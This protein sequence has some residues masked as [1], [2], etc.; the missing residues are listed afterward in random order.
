MIIYIAG[1]TGKD[2]DFEK[3][4]QI[5]GDC[6]ELIAGSVGWG[7]DCLAN[8]CT[9]SNLLRSILLDSDSLTQ[10]QIIQTAYKYGNEL[11]IV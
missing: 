3:E 7:V 2:P 4:S 10:F 11:Y 6:L 9:I 5:A 1:R 8:S